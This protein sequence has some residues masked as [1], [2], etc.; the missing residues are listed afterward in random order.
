MRPPPVVVFGLLLATTL[1]QASPSFRIDDDVRVE[2]SVDGSLRTLRASRAQEPMLA[3]HGFCHAH[4]LSL[5]SEGLGC[6][7]LLAEELIARGG[8]FVP[9]RARDPVV[10]MT[11]GGDVEAQVQRACADLATTSDDGADD[12]LWSCGDEL[13]ASVRALVPRAAAERQ[14]PLQVG[15]PPRA[16]VM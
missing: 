15:A 4:N 3:A 1:D 7:S 11:G 10:R 14:R 2:A 6:T 9:W 8:R 13:L 12:E 5:S 16:V